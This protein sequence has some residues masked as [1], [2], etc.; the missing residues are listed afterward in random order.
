MSYLGTDSQT[1]RRLVRSVFQPAKGRID[2]ISRGRAR[3]V[4]RRD[5]AWLPAQTETG[6]HDQGMRSQSGHAPV[7]L[8]YSARGIAGFVAREIHHDAFDVGGRA[9]STH[10]DPRDDRGPVGRIL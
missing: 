2:P 4:Q 8:E 9:G 10:R 3:P 5:A 7:D 6:A 1:G